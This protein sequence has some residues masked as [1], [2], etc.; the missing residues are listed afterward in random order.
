MRVFDIPRV[1][2]DGNS[3]MCCFMLHSPRHIIALSFVVLEEFTVKSF[4]LGDP[5]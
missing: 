4:S 2:C 3:I 1:Y 5:G